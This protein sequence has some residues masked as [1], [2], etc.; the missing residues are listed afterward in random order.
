MPG[1]ADQPA[2]ARERRTFPACRPRIPHR[3][4]F[5]TRRQ[6]YRKQHFILHQIAHRHFPAGDDPLRPLGLQRLGVD[7][8]LRRRK[9]ERH[10]NAQRKLQG[11]QASLADKLQRAADPETQRGVS[12]LL[13]HAQQFVLECSFVRA[14]YVAQARKTGYRPSTVQPGAGPREFKAVD[15]RLV[16]HTGTNGIILKNLCQNKVMPSP[17]RIILAS[18]SRY[19]RALLERL[20]IAFECADPQTDE[21][22][23]PGEAGSATALRLA[24]AKAH[25]VASSYP[26]A[27]IIGSDQVATCEGARLDKPGNHAN[28]LRQLTAMSGKT[29]RFD[30][31][32]A[33]LDSR[34]GKLD[35]KVVAC[36]VTFRRLDAQQIER[37]L[38]LEQPYDCAGSAKVEGLGITLI[39]RI[40][41]EDPT[42]LIGLPLIALTQL[43][44]DAGAPVLG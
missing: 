15:D 35:T 26:D 42:S 33:L 19:R 24:Q 37:Y 21:T 9:P 4:A 5:V 23:R 3:A 31:A 43:L 18:T 22:A 25:A 11:A 14:Q 7:F 38:R 17:R 1:S 29:A 20:G 27:L 39:E 28:A 32:V 10:V 36:D 6:R 40:E 30:T 16:R 41:T 2:Q 34:S 44:A 12:P 13:R 8:S